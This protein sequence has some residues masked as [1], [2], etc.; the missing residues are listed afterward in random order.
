[1]GKAAASKKKATAKK[2][3]KRPAC[4]ELMKLN[5]DKLTV[6]RVV[7]MFD[8]SKFMSDLAAILQVENLHECKI[9][10]ASMYDGSN[11]PSEVMNVMKKVLG[12]KPVQ[13]YGCLLALK[14]CVG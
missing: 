12:I 13:L 8:Q 4:K 6:P 1:M 9:P 10:W 2:V 11:M 5:L 7:S 14:M 3:C